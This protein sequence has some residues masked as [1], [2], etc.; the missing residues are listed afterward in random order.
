MGW[1]ALRR[2]LPLFAPMLLAACA[3]FGG[4]K[5]IECPAVRILQEGAEVRFFRDGPGRDLTDVTVEARFDGVGGQCEYDKGRLEIAFVVQATAA[6]GSAPG[7][8]QR[9]IPYFVAVV[10]AN[11]RILARQRFEL[12]VAFPENFLRVAVQDEIG[13]KLPLANVVEAPDYTIFIGFELSRD[14][15]D[16]QQ[17]DRRR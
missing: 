12:P 7:P 14:E 15:F 1:A 11:G 2:A 5:S 13:I 16:L 10:D 8:R 9:P 3:T 4:D 6:L 17:F